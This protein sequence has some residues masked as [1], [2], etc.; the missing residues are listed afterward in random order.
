MSMRSVIIKQEVKVS[1]VVCPYKWF[2]SIGVKA[3]KTLKCA[4]Y[5][6]KVRFILMGNCSTLFR[7]CI[8]LK[9]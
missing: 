2:K 6:L 3:I 9:S 8:Y 7:N 1:S 4:S 5:E